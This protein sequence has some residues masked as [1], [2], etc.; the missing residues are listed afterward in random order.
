MG[1]GFRPWLLA[2]AV[3][4]T[5]S[6]A[7][8]QP[9]LKPPAAGA[10]QAAP[11]ASAPSTVGGIVVEARRAPRSDKALEQAVGKL[12]RD[13]GQPGP[14]GQIARWREPI[15]PKVMGLAQSFDEFVSQ[16]IKD[17]AARVGV[18]EDGACREAN[19]LVVFTVEP[20]KLMADVRDH[21]PALLGYHFAGERKAVATFHGPIE[22]WYVSA[23]SMKTGIKDYRTPR[24]IDVANGPEPPAGTGSHIPPEFASEFALALVVVD[25]NQLEGQAIGPVADKIAMITLSK[26]AMQETALKCSPLPSVMDV[27]ASNCPSGASTKG[28]TAYDEAFLKGL[29]AYQGNELRAFERQEIAKRIIKDT[30]TAP[31]SLA[32]Q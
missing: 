25:A 16:R 9:A 15:C 8:A 17:V 22:S 29:Y 28:L 2:C 3:C 13:L 1:V 18:P 7:D 4:L 11:A 21:H 31:P 14:I 30:T 20:Q 19:V 27:L 26:P 10:L 12:V 6:I 32:D 23:T 24:H 5:A